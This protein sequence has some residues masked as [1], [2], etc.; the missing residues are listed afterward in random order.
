M[1]C[2]SVT[3]TA[4][5]IPPGKVGAAKEERDAY[6]AENQQLLKDRTRLELTIRDL[7]D[8]VMGDNKSKVGQQWRSMEARAEAGR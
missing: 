8:E 2:F 3:W 6:N 7:S 5:P 4:L 1:R